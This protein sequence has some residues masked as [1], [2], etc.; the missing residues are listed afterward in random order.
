M[1]EHLE[2]GKK[3][4]HDDVVMGELLQELKYEM[5]QIRCGQARGIY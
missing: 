5:G 4:E 1:Y 3:R 2:L